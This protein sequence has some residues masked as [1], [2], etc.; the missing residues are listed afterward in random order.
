MVIVFHDFHIQR[1]RFHYRQNNPIEPKEWQ[2]QGV[3]LRYRSSGK[4]VS[5][6]LEI[7]WT[8][9]GCITIRRAGSRALLPHGTLV[10]GNR[11]SAEV[12]VSFLRGGTERIGLSSCRRG[13]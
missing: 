6:V 12:G 5:H 13:C 4:S 1:S 10:R 11:G 9:L 7:A 8:A 2:D 3:L